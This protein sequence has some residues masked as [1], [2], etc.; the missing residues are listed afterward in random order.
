MIIF[1]EEQIIELHKQL[2]EETG[3]SHGVRDKAL[4]DSAYSAAFQCFNNQEL[5]SDYS[6]K[7]CTFSFRLNKKSSVYRRKQMNRD[8]CYADSACT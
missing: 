3:G 5:F 4:L 7:S 2:I 6:A 8:T 1:N